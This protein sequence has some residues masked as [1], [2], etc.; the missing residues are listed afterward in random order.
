MSAKILDEAIVKLRTE[1]KSHFE[2]EMYLRAAELA[3]IAD[4]LEQLKA[5]KVRIATLEREK[6]AWTFEKR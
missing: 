1:A 4:W 6:E 3:Q 2:W 5:A